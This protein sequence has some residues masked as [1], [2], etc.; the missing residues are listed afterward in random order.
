MKGA[1][2]LAELASSFHVF[3]T[4]THVACAHPHHVHLS[5]VQMS[6]PTEMLEQLLKKV[7]VFLF[8]TINIV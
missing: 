5:H 2:F 3:P 6:Q 4:L 1:G 7:S 8:V